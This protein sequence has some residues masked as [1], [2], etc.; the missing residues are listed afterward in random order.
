MIGEDLPTVALKRA[1][2]QTPAGATGTGFPQ[3]YHDLWFFGAALFFFVSQ[4]LGH[5][6]AKAR[7]GT[8][9]S[10]CLYALLLPLALL[11]ITHSGYYVPVYAPLP[12]FALWLAFRW[13]K[14]PPSRRAA[15]F[16][17]TSATARPHIPTK[18]V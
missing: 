12:V 18:S 14:P 10:L 13:A 4:F 5:H 3:L 1:G 11:A 9:K 6:F 17:P 7:A 16:A 2:Y 15:I 8:L